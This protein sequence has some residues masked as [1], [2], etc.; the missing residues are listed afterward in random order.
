[1]IEGIVCDDFD[2]DRD[3][4]EI[5]CPTHLLAGS[6]AL[7]GAMTATDIRKVSGRI[8]SCSTTVWNDIGH[9]THQTRGE[10]YAAE[11]LSFLDEAG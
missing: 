4:A 8:P 1:M 11:L 7:G 5:V 2:A 10:S 6:E 9:L 3:L